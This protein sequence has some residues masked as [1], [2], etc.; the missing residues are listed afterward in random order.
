MWKQSEIPDYL[1][2]PDFLDKT[3]EIN[4][5]RQFL[6]AQAETQQG[7]VGQAPP[8][9]EREVPEVQAI[10]DIG[11]V[12]TPK[13]KLILEPSLQ[14]SN[15]QVNRFTFVGVE[16]VVPTFLIGLLEAVDT[17]RDLYSAGLTA[18]YGITNRLEAEAKVSYLYRDDRITAIV[19]QVEDT[20]EQPVQTTD[21]LTGDGLGDAEFTL[22]YQINRGQGGWP[23]FIGN[24][25]Y[26]SN[27][28]KGPFDVDRDVE[29]EETELPTGS[30]FHAVEP[31]VTV[32]YPSDPAVFFANIGYV[33]NISEDVNEAFPTP[34]PDD[35]PN[36]RVIVGDVDPG[37]VFRISFGMAYSI[38]ERTSFTLGYKH[39]F[40][41]ETET[42]FI[43]EEETAPG[44][45][46]RRRAVQT[47]STLDVGALLLGFG[48]R[49]NEQIA[50]NLNLELGIT[51]DAPDV[52]LTLRVPY[53]F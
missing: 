34:D 45:I 37:D 29:G 6:L 17:D 15:S 41:E 21:E 46:T 24:L 9:R 1:R 14:F 25:R 39:D 3:E 47:S 40:I 35:S 28:G 16:I 2:D 32:L 26:K 48:L 36:N 49:I 27:T 53:S 11:G 38:N 52:A 30:G 22:H 50:A 8:E 43:S 23:F 12:L 4:P 5:G 7:P 31:S 18:R 42:E 51:A 33:F 13:G 44:V 19:P 20:E 10:A